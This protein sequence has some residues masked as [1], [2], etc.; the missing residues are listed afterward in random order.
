MGGG[1]GR[2]AEGGGGVP[3]R[4]LEGGCEQRIE[5]FGGPVWGGGGPV[6]GGGQVGYERR[7]EVIVKMQNKVGGG[8]R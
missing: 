1:S 3:T 8:G 4:G 5:E 2:R 6:G 7:I